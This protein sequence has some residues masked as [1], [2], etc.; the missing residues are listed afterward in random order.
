M[1][2]DTIF[3][4]L[5]VEESTTYT[6]IEVCSHYHIPQ[7][8][9]LEMVEYGIFQAKTTKQESLTFSAAELRKIE[10]GFRLHRD[11]DVNLA[12]VALALE[13]LEQIDNL[14]HELNVLRKLSQ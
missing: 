11:L 14:H 5:V 13:L 12:G 9:L 8:L 4:G 1:T 10:K 7:E 6:L 3:T 2:K